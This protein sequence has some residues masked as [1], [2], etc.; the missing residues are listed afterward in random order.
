MIDDFLNRYREERAAIANNKRLSE[1]GKKEKLDALDKAK[2]EEARKLVKGLR[3][4]AVKNALELHE[5][6]AAFEEREAEALENMNYGR[7][8]FEAKAI[9]SRVALAETFEDIRDAWAEAKQSGDAHKIK[10]WKEVSGKAIKDFPENEIYEPW[11]KNELLHDIQNAQLRISKEPEMVELERENFAALK[12]I[13]ADAAALG[14]EFDNVSGAVV[15]RV[16]DGI[17][18]EE[19]RIRPEFEAETIILPYDIG[20]KTESAADVYKRL[21]EAHETNL[22]VA[23][24]KFYK[25]GPGID[26]EFDVM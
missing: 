21:E 9:E 25:N 2:R 24:E 1:M 22:A 18:F 8:N 15:G 23:N 10:A 12:A 3:K 16:F 11:A 5:I 19:N 13:E 4:T 20:E 26:A 14:S 7:L 17:Q 6:Q